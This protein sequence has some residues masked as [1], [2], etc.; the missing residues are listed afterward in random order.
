VFFLGAA[1]NAYA[2]LETYTEGETQV[3]AGDQ[4]TNMYRLNAVGSI[5]MKKLKK[6]DEVLARNPNENVNAMDISQIEQLIDSNENEQ[7]Q[8]LEQM[9][10][11][12]SK[13][14]SSP[15][16][17]RVMPDK[18]LYKELSTLSIRETRDTA[19]AVELLKQLGRR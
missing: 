6:I 18:R 11:K 14:L 10:K 2:Y 1:S 7:K 19:V 12:V 16:N 17:L 4:N 8:Q 13:T 5:A 15:E 9:M 3:T